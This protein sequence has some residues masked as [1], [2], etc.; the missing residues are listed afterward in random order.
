MNH[1]QHVSCACG[2][3]FKVGQKVWEK[4]P[5]KA[6]IK[7][8]NTNDAFDFSGTSLI[9]ISFHVDDNNPITRF[10]SYV[11]VKDALVCYLFE[12]VEYSLFPRRTINPQL[13]HSVFFLISYSWLYRLEFE[14]AY[15]RS[16]E[17]SR[18]GH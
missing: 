6:Y 13:K 1:G 8:E 2:I 7:R 10:V 16:S 11:Y 15:T 18:V 9:L 3:A 14:Q 12:S 4:K 5:K 17:S